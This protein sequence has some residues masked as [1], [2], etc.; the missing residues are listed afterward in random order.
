MVSVERVKEYSELEQ[1]A[2]EIVEPRP[3]AVWPH[4]GQIR[5]NRLCVRYAEDLP[6]VLNDISLTIKGGE[7]IGTSATL[8]CKSHLTIS[9]GIVGSTGCGK[10][11][12][13]TFVAAH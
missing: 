7:K 6:L 11:W 1:E 4:Q 13:N 9:T 3:P 5:L 8:L 12:N 2:P 10:V